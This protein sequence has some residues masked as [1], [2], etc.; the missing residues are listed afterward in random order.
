MS[1]ISR[2]T[3]ERSGMPGQALDDLDPRIWEVRRLLDDVLR[4]EISIRRAWH[5]E[6]GHLRAGGCDL[7][8][9]PTIR[10]ARDVVAHPGVELSEKIVG[11]L[12]VIAR[13]PL[14]QEAL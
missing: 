11:V 5:E 12:A 13:A 1:A 9:S 3:A 10:S 2:L 14:G 8:A 6:H 7:E 4:I